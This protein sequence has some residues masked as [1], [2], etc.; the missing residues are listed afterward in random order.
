MRDEILAE[1]AWQ[2]G[3]GRAAHIEVAVE[4]G[5]AIL[6]GRVDTSA[7]RRGAVY[8]ALSAEGVTDVVDGLGVLASGGPVAPN[9]ALARDARRALEEGAHDRGTGLKTVTC[10]G[11]VD[12]YGAVEHASESRV[13]ESAIRRHTEAL[14]V[15]NRVDVRSDFAEVAPRGHAARHAIPAPF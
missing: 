2:L 7:E 13:A 3:R 8:A 15:T 4:R 1:L 11:W 5:L 10:K 6:T 14:G 9:A 12:L